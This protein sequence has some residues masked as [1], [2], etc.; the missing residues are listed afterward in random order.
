LAK[1]LDCPLLF[2]GKDFSRTDV[3]SALG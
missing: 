3:K 2:I 1:E